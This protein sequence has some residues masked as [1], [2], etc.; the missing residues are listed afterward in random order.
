MRPSQAWPIFAVLTLLACQP[1]HG[2]RFRNPAPS[3]RI[4][5]LLEATLADTMGPETDI[6]CSDMAPL[7]TPLGRVDTVQVMPD[8][9]RTLMIAFGDTFDAN[10]RYCI[11]S[12]VQGGR[13]AD[14]LYLRGDSILP[15]VRGGVVT[16]QLQPTL[17]LLRRR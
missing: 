3:R 7:R 17:E 10:A 8:S 16:V 13:S 15:H 14:T 4:V 5:S 1:T 11:V 9:S 2:F 12:S 6:P